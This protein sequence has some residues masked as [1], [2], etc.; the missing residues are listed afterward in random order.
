MRKRTLTPRRI[1]KAV[2]VFYKLRKAN[3]R[4]T[5]YDYCYNYFHSFESK[6]DI[7]SDENIE[8]SC[9]VLGFYLASWGMFR[10]SSA[11]LQK[12]IIILRPVIRWI[13]SEKAMPM[14]NIDVGNYG[15]SDNIRKLLRAFDTL[16]GKLNLTQENKRTLVTKIMLGVFGNTPAFDSY[17]TKSFGKHFG[18]RCKFGRFNEDS[19]ECIREFY[20]DNKAIIDRLQKNKYTLDFQTGKKTNNQYTIAKIIDMVGFGQSL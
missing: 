7:A 14:W 20:E 5:S 9:L 3:H 17:F 11:I 10:G 1:N 4:Y 12:S 6:K 16:K 2:R 13:A 19:L 18:E 8:K 15:E